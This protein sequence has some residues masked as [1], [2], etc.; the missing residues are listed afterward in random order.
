MTDI[1]YCPDCGE[2]ISIDAAAFC[3]SCGSALPERDDD[4]ETVAEGDDGRF[5]DDLTPPE[6][7]ERM[8][9]EEEEEVLRDAA[10]IVDDPDLEEFL[11]YAAE[12]K[13]T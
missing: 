7:V 6:K 1:N 11:R 13:P 12:C 10:D 3:P 4:T 9:K 8:T 2:P 5:D